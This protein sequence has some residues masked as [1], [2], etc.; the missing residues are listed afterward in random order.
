MNFANRTR[1][2]SRFGA[3]IVVAAALSGCSMMPDW[4]GG[5]S[6]RPAQ[7][8]DSTKPPPDKPAATNQGFPYLADTPDRPAAPSTPDD[9][10]Q[11]AD[12]LGTARTQQNY[13]TE[14]LQA[15]AETAAAPPPAEAPQDD[16][17]QV[18]TGA[19]APPAASSD[20]D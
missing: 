16:I 3:V 17:A 19:K 6:A 7:P 4:L 13:N 1:Y 18:D 9:Q 2:V 15:G 11:V 20:T 12:S 14:Q 8:A 10:K 5:A